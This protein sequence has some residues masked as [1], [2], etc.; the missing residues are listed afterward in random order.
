MAGKGT[1]SGVGRVAPK[2]ARFAGQMDSVQVLS[3]LKDLKNGDFTVRLP[4]GEGGIA[5]EIAE[6]F[7]AVVERLS[8]STTELEQLGKLVG[9]EGRINHRVGLE[10]V[11]GGWALRN[12]AVNELV[13]DLVQPI[14]E[15]ARVIGAVAKG[16]LS[17]RM[18]PEIDGRP[19]EGE[20]LRIGNTV[21]AMVHQLSSFASEVAR[22]AR[23][24]GTDGKL[25]G[26]ADVNGAAGTWKDLTD[27]VNSM[28]ANLTGHYRWGLNPTAISPRKRRSFSIRE[29][30]SYF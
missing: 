28:A 2:T 13:T 18:A 27:N 8:H 15:V 29:T 1:V 6:T 14:V 16:D 23:E 12:D 25:G 20:F 9:K 24:V 21:N 19:L 3:A 17:Q 7:N 5:G 4:L 11:S 22:V 10:D 30:W 26:Q